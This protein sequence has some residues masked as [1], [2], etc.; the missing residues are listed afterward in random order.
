[1]ARRIQFTD[2]HQQRAFDF[3]NRMN[4]PHHNVT[5]QVDL[6][7][8]PQQFKNRKLRFT[9]G[10]LYLLCRTANEVPHFRRRIRG[11][12]IWEHETV[13]P[14]LTVK[15]A[16]SDTFSFCTVKY[17]HDHRR[18]VEY[19]RTELA[20]M[21]HEPS[22]ADEQ[23]RDDYLFLSSLP[24]FSFTGLQHAMPYHPT[25][26]VP[27]ITWGKTFTD[28]RER[29]RLPLSVQVHHAVVDGEHLGQFF[30]KLEGFVARPEVLFGRVDG[31]RNT[32]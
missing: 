15:T 4:H 28:H 26:S 24:W 18:F 2:P 16:A 11:D 21:Q 23:G 29:L 32:D 19:F 1:M 3:F 27:R 9:E 10:I 12:E 30:Q 14:S 25:D 13:H 7:D 31:L 5:V 8:L 17:D 6:G 22:F 20:R